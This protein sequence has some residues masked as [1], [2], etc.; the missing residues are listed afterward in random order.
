[1]MRLWPPTCYLVEKHQRFVHQHT[2]FDISIHIPGHV[3]SYPIYQT[4][5][6]IQA[7]Q[8]VDIWPVQYIL[9][10]GMWK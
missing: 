6:D 3:N 10:Y 2:D 8:Y 4:P 7:M 1:M 9:K 5:L